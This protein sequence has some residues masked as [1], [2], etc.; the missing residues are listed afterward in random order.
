LLV[1]IVVAVAGAGCDDDFTKKKRD[2][3]PGDGGGGSGG[4]A[5]TGG[6]GGTGGMAGRGGTGGATFDA[7]LDAPRDAPGAEVARLDV[8]PADAPR[9]AAAD[10]PRDTAVDA[11][12][13]T[14]ADAP[15]DAAADVTA[16]DAAVD[17]ATPADAAPDSPAM[18]DSAPDTSAPDG[19][20]TMAFMDITPCNQ[21]SAYVTAP[22]TITFLSG[23]NGF[24]PSCL[25]LARGSTVTFNGDMG[26]H[27]VRARPGGTAGNPVDGS[28]MVTFNQAG[29][30]PFH[31]ISHQNMIGVVWVTP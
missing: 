26:S 7:G 21:E 8:A 10:A 22:L 29:F 16:P 11:L 23:P 6:S 30:F 17:H 9:D 19:A 13:D 27:P 25:K 24:T 3:G 5:G 1:A 28:T 15:R 20:T 14:G 2:A 12:R 4:L 31:C 18:P